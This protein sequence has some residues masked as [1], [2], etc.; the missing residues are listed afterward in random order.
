MQEAALMTLLL[1]LFLNKKLWSDYRLTKGLKKYYSSV[2]SSRACMCLCRI[3]RP[4]EAETFEESCLR[5]RGQFS[6]TKVIFKCFFFF[7]FWFTV[8]LMHTL[9]F[10]FP[11]FPMSHG[12]C[13]INIAAILLRALLDSALNKKLHCQSL[14]QIIFVLIPFLLP[15][16]WLHYELYCTRWICMYVDYQKTTKCFSQSVLCL[17]NWDTGSNYSVLHCVT[18]HTTRIHTP[19]V[20]PWV[21]F[22]ILP[23]N[24]PSFIHTVLYPSSLY[25]SFQLFFDPPLPQSIP[26]SF[27]IH[28]L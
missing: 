24:T 26:Y 21:I 6:V 13:L 27:S 28:P 14:L 20:N 25:P 23:F 5:L 4:C 18:I 8:M 9:S 22:I 7:F 11:S 12:V 1:S 16:I 15:D 19:W 10:L 2:I 17:I 3:D